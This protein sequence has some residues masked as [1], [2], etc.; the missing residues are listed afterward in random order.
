MNAPRPQ[1]NHDHG[2]QADRLVDLLALQA[3]EGLSTAEARELDELLNALSTEDQ[4]AWRQTVT[5]V[6][7]AALPT[8]APGAISPALRAKLA[9]DAESILRK[10]TGKV[11]RITSEPPS[12]GAAPISRPSSPIFAYA[13][14]V[15]AAAAIALATYT[16]FPTVGSGTGPVGVTDVAS[17]RRAVDGA[18]DRVKLPFNPGVDELK[19]VSGEIVWS[20][21][22]QRGYMTFNGLAVN[23]PK[24]MQYQLWIVDA[25]R[26]KHPV[27]GGVFDVSA[28]GTVTVPVA[29]RLAV[30]SPAA[31]A[32]TREKPG[33]VVVSAGP[34]VLV[35]AKAKG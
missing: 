24:L 28:S 29:S 15:A 14:W 22:L 10:G 2:P 33:G 16:Y 19:G 11:L 26:D 13:G 4:R 17:A 23:D 3:S 8:D 9:A 30:K 35:A 34:L 12:A 7:Y 1:H 31:F 20:D 6:E 18:A 5:S 25:G 21:T 32:I 27:D